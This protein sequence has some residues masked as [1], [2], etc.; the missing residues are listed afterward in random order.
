MGKRKTKQ[1]KAG[2]YSYA[3]FSSPE[4]AMGDSERRQLEAARAW[5]EQ[6]GLELDESDMLTDRG[7]SGYHG[8][9]RTKGKLGTFLAAVGAGKIL[10]GSILLVENLDRLGRE[11]PAKT[12]REII[13][14]LWDHGITLQTLSPRETYEP[15]CENDPM[16]LAL[17]IYLQRAW[18]E[19]ERKGERVRAARARARELAR[20]EGR[21]LTRAAPAWLTVTEAGQ[22]E[23][24]PEA[25]ETIHLAFD[26]KQK[27][28]GKIRIANT[29][30]REGTWTPPRRGKL[31]CEGNGKGSGWRESYVQKILRNRAVIG[32][33]QPFTRID[34]KRKPAGDPIPDY[35]PR[36]VEPGLF[37]AVQARF[38]GNG[39]K[40]GQTGKARNLFVHLVKCAYCGAT[41]AFVDKGKPPKGNRYLVCDQARRGLGCSYT[42]V[43]YDEFEN[44]VLENCR[45]LRPDQVLPAPDEKIRLCQ[46][47]RERVQGKGAELAEIKRQ[48]EN[49]ID[50]T[51]RT[52]DRGV[53]DRYEARV[54]KLDGQVA[55]IEKQ[56]AKDE[57][58]LRKAESGL[59]SFTRWKRGLAELQ[60]GIVGNVELRLRL[61]AHLREL[62]DRIDVFPVGFQRRHDPDEAERALEGLSGDERH[63]A[64]E[65][66]DR[67]VDSFAETIEAAV[68]DSSPDWKPDTEFYAFLEN[69]TERRMSREGRFLRIHFTTGA[70]VDVVPEGSLASGLELVKDGRYNVGWRFVSPGIDRL[71][72]E[73][74]GRN[75]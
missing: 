30:N 70:V 63:K 32:E 73:F 67:S 69:V 53:R 52:N 16:F 68:I 20:A 64:R 36:I 25:V 6:Q 66:Y 22:F 50:Q 54:R 17:I 38:A 44:A 27:G 42:S 21:I 39:G 26:L 31:K 62:I 56:K 12:L 15:G 49:L 19:S 9:H 48:T 13:F 11:G 74:E 35:Y 34:G 28:L 47:L 1:A 2:V 14:K 75:R 59:R 65:T 33:Y 71:W 61:R 51:A 24:I 23:P 57:K 5:A 43:R 41:M 45:R 37:H 60:E 29:L 18:D 72:K 4:Q 58:E 46:S 7:L 10:D 40:G 55:G 3:R 8:D